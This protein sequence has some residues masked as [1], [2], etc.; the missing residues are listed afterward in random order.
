MWLNRLLVVCK[1]LDDK[2]IQTLNVKFYRRL[3]EQCYASTLQFV[4]TA[5]IFLIIIYLL[6]YIFCK[7]GD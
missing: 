4:I 5:C 6:C 2:L 3:A 7:V 1:I